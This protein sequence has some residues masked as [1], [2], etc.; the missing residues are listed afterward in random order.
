MLNR[1]NNKHGAFTLVEIMIMV[2]IIALG[3]WVFKREAP[4]IAEEL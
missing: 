3:Y 4:L 1:L 2:A